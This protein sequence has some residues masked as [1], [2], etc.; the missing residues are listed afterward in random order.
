MTDQATDPIVLYNSLTAQ[1]TMETLHPD[2]VGMYVCGPTVYNLAHI[3]NADL[4]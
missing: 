2:R 1:G 4:L 3:G